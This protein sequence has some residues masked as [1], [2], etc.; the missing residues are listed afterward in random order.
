MIDPTSRD[1]P[2]FK[3][4]LKVRSGV[5]VRMLCGGRSL[6]SSSWGQKEHNFRPTLLC[7]SPQASLPLLKQAEHV[8]TWV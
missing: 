4:L 8:P 7:S 1:D 6:G 3:E 2:R 5:L